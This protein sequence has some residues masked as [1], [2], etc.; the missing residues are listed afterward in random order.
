MSQC[1][2]A[3]LNAI[4]GVLSH[5]A[6]HLTPAVNVVSLGDFIYLLFCV[7]RSIHHLPK[8]LV[9]ILLTAYLGL[10]EAMLQPCLLQ[11]KPLTSAEPHTHT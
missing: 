10:L 11:G 2:A 1:H 7:G 3:P 6:M 4:P 9:D 8:L 5:A